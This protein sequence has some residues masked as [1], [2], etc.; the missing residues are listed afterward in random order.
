MIISV[1]YIKWLVFG[2]THIVYCVVESHILNTFSTKFAFRRGIWNND[3][4]R[5][6]LLAQGYCVLVPFIICD[7]LLDSLS[8]PTCRR[9]GLGVG[10]VFN[11]EPVSSAGERKVYK[12]VVVTSYIGLFEEMFILTKINCIQY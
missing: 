10:M 7:I 6:S 11:Y 5:A 1:C 4:F 9:K 3:L 2:W 8:S 12:Q